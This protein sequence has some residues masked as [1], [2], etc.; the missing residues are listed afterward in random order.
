M[1]IS[2]VIKTPNSR[3]SA[4]KSKIE[5]ILNLVLKIWFKDIFWCSAILPKVILT[6]YIEKP[7]DVEEKIFVFLNSFYV[8]FLLAKKFEGAF[9]PGIVFDVE[10]F[11]EL[12]N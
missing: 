10:A 12:A 2:S 4:L 11:K 5:Q 6:N 3:R 1:F 7:D 8:F 9:L